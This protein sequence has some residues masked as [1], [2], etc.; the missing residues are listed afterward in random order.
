MTTLTAPA[1]VDVPGSTHVLRGFARSTRAELLRLGKWAALWLTIGVELLLNVLFGYV[2][3][4]VSYRSSGDSGISEGVPKQVLLERMLPAAIPHSGVAG[5]P[6]FAGALVLILGALA[7][8]SG[9]GWGT[10]KTVAL[11]GPGRVTSLAGSL[12]ALLA[13]VVGLVAA[14]FATDV[15]VSL[16]VASSESQPVVWPAVTDLVASF[17][18]GV[19]IMGAWTLGGVLV[20]TLARSPAL[21]VGL[22][23]V[24]VLAIENLL[25]GVGEIWA[26]LQNVTDLLPG[27]AAGS[28]AGALGAVPV[29]D[30]GGTPGVLTTLGGASAVGLLATYVVV[31]VTATAALVRRR[32]VT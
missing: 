9:Y 22:G 1:R 27:T 19:L 13:A 18:G 26:P 21:S 12:V 10:V 5:M 17:G 23:L 24:W 16:L 8:G 2:F 15:A 25:R 20:G 30:P 6:M 14:L 32:D 7:A 28:L 3:N 29:T 11:Q 31:F 4:Y